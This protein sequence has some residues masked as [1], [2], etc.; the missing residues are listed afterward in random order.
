MLYVY[1]MRQFWRSNVTD[2]QKEALFSCALFG[3]TTRCGDVSGE[4]RTF[5]KGEILYQPGDCS[6]SLVFLLSGKVAVYN[7]SRDRRTPLNMIGKGGLFGAAALFGGETCYLTTV[8]AEQKT[9]AFFVEEAEWT[10][11][12]GTDP[13]LAVNYAK[14]LTGRIRHLNAIIDSLSAG[15]AENRLASFLLLQKKKEFTL[16]FSFS[17][18]AERLGIGRASLYRAFDTLEK[19]GIISRSDRTVSVLDTKKLSSLSEEKQ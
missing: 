8:I 14:F 17:E 11:L 3:G 9:E 7:F 12:I 10:R 18:L 16:P 5:E 1:Q 2:K 15:S 13:V 6:G 19:S 4:V